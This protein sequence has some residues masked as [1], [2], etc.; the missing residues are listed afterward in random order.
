[1]TRWNAFARGASVLHGDQPLWR[2]FDREGTQDR[3]GFVEVIVSPALN[4]FDDVLR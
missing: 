2:A 1:M 3:D 4:A